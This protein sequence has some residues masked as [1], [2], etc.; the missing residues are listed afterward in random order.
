MSAKE[1]S[2]QEAFDTVV[3]H[4]RAQKVRS[5][6][7]EGSHEPGNCA[8]RGENGT[9]CAFGPF[10]PDDKYTPQMEGLNVLFLIEQ[11]DFLKPLREHV[12]LLSAMQEIHD[13]YTTL[14]AWERLWRQ[15][16]QRFHLKYTPPE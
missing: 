8:Y 2:A 4:L 11:Y 15:T 3:N 9:K 10:I 1:I 14:Q 6:L 7:P 12:Y 16:A 13:N 5:L